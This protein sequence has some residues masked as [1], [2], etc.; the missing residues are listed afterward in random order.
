MSV[1]RVH[2]SSLS[3]HWATPKA[4][5]D[6]LDKEFHFTLDPCPILSKTEFAMSWEGDRIFCNPPYGPLIERY[7]QKAREAVC[8][9]YLLPARTDTRWFHDYCLQ[10]NEI[11]FL[12]G[13]LRFGDG[14]GRATFP[15]M[16]VVFK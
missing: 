6:A 2:F 10:A 3:V 4:I 12:R 8:A 1:S 9:V 13:R 14:K 16:V 5:Y 7:L 11:R 15:S